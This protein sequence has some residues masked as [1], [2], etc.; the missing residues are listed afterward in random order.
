MLNTQELKAALKQHM[1]EW[2]GVSDDDIVFV[3]LSGL[4]NIIY[5][6]DHSKGLLPPVVFR[7]FGDA[8]GL[9]ERKKENI[10]YKELGEAG[11]GPQLYFASEGFRIEQFLQ[12]IHHPTDLEL[13]SP[14]LKKSIVRK[15]VE[16]HQT[17]LPETT[18]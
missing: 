18:G 7:K 8:S 3:R 14:A 6:V 15:L 11:I 2:E 4:T 1:K 17:V 13:K 12:G 9:L 5:R 16:L 10:I